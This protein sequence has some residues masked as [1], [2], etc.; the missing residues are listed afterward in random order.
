MY[1]VE[2][3]WLELLRFQVRRRNWP[4]GMRSR[5]DLLR[6]RLVGQTDGVFLH[7]RGKYMPVGGGICLHGEH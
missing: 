3:Q 1:I 6:G 5:R 4:V 7:L 2:W